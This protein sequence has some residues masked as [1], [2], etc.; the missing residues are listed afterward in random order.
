MRN[1]KISYKVDIFGESYVLIS[2][3]SADF[4]LNS[5]LLVDELM[6]EI[7]KKSARI[8]TKK[9]PILAAVQLALQLVSLKHELVGFKHENEKNKQ[10]HITLI[11]KLDTALNKDYS[12]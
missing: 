8:E 10:T 12:R 7:V 6:R 2:D 9:V 5:A 3:E 11:D 4:V 1:E